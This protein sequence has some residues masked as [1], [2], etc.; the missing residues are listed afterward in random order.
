MTAN[1]LLPKIA[2]ES[3]E[4]LEY[5]AFHA[6][7]NDLP[8]V[9]LLGDSISGGY[10]DGVAKGLE[11]QAYVTRLGSSKPVSLP[12][13]FDEVRLALSQH[14]YAVIHFNNGLHGWDYTEEEYAQGLTQLV[15]YLKTNAPQ[16]KLIWA[17]STPW[18]TGAPE[19]AG[20]EPRNE[21]VI[22]R[23]QIAVRQME[24]AGI[25]INDLYSLMEPNHALLCDGV[26]Y[27]AEGNVLLVEQVLVHIRP[28][29]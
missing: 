4:W 5:R 6:E 10:F 7:L 8:R 12:A 18:R 20:F 29:L 11:G 28:A 1:T 21:R 22:V 27:T 25:P 9:L 16:A 26:H 14:A 15:D 13:Y 23:N 17:S 24:Q 2:L 19:F 3:T